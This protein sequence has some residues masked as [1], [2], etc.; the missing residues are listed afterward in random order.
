MLDEYSIEQ[1][2]TQIFDARTK[3]YFSEVLSC[4]SAGNYRSS[5][6]MLWSVAVCDLLF[7]LQ[8]LDDLYGDTKA[9]DILT[10][11][12]KLQ[13]ENERSPIWETKLIELVAGQTQ[14][15][16]IAE[17]ENLLHLQRQRHLAAHP[18]INTN[19]ELHRPNRETVRA[20]IRNTLDGVL[21]K[22]PILS[23]QI[24]NE[25]VGD[26][27]QA[28]GILIDD[29][30]LRAYLESKYYSR[31][32][33][34]VEK[35]VF[36]AFWKFVF[37][38][39]NEP[40]EKNRVIN[41]RALRLLF[42][43][44]PSQFKAQIEADKDYFSTIATGGAPVFHLVAFLS[45]APL[46]YKLLA[47]HAKTKIQHAAESDDST[48]CLAWFI[49]PSLEE[50]A[51]RL[52]EWIAGEDYPKIECV[53]WTA[54]KEL[55]DSPEWAKSVIRLANKYYVASKSFDFADR[56]FPEVIKPLLD[57]YE[58][59]DCVDL[60]QGV[61]GNYQTWGRW[62]AASD[63]RELRDRMLALDANF[64]FSPYPDCRLDN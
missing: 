28:S 48:R 14:L 27:E 11:I 23:K 6:V 21:T 33:P 43:R 13:Q 29:K 35:A 54:L 50:H 19:F 39:D 56:R 1:R 60:I 9:K 12:G 40:C 49:A 55:S 44:N 7:K 52:G 34:E 16:D 45:R 8:S 15:L 5:V 37:H 38:L 53:T 32:N 46:L 63:H 22:A 36:K 41:S 17:Q 57:K 42:G 18:V 4:Y 10:E 3:E 64:D 26:L 31:F 61:Q 51:A 59:D 20:L 24:V 58:I 30:K 2:A 25:L 47:D 62:R